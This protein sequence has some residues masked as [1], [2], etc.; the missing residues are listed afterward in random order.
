MIGG[1][2]FLHDSTKGGF[3][4]AAHSSKLVVYA[5]VIGNFV[6]AVTKFVAAALT[7]SSAMLSEG[8]H[9]LVDTGNGL[10]LL[11]GIHRSARPADEKHPFGYGLELYFWTLIVAIMIFG[12]GGGISLYEG[13]LHVMHPAPLEDPTINYIVL[14]I[15]VV[16]EGI[17]WTLALKGFLRLKGKAGFWRAI[18]RSK[19]PTTFAVLF[20]DTAALLGLLVAFLGIA[21]GHW[22]EVPELDGVASILIGLILMAV[23]GVL[24]Y[25]TRGLLIGESAHPETVSG[26]REL[27]AADADVQRVRRPLTLHFGPDAILLA[28]DVQFKESLTAEAIERAIDRL[29]AAVRAEYPRVKHIYLEAASISTAKHEERRAGN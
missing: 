10:L 5:A 19:D 29:E 11:L 1:G 6:I 16:V 17:A 3:P 4:V 22:L 9:S 28:L 24:I 15:A 7:G 2:K 27:V 26:I 8:I 12:V 20:E 23:A 21:L 14:G 13:V 25:E 18:Q